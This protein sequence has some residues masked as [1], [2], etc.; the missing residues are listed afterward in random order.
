MKSRKKKTRNE[1][2]VS[3]AM[4]RSPIKGVV[5]SRKCSS[6][7]HHEIGF[8]TMAGRFLA[9]KPGMKIAALQDEKKN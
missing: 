4:R 2:T 1:R 8:I 3:K 5:I 9:L 6:C 7:G